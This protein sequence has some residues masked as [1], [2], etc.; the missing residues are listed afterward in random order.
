MVVG[1][2]TNEV[3]TIV[4]GSGPGGYVAA[5]RAAQLGQ[6]VVIVEKETIGG[7]CLN[8]GCIPSKA[9]IQV[10]HDYA[11]SKMVSPYGLSFGETSLDFAKAQ[12]WKNSQVVSK[13]TM[14][15]ETLLK[16]NKVTIVK[17]EAHFVSKDT[18]FVTPEDGLGEGYRFKNVIL[19]LGSRPIELKAFPF[20]GDILDSTGLLNLQ[21]VPKE[22]AI[23]GGGYIGMELAMAYANLG[24]HVTILEGMDRVLGGFEADLVKPVLDQAAQL[25][26]TIITGAKAS[27]YEKTAQGIDLFYQNG[28]KEEKIQADKVAVLVGRRPNTDNV[29][30]EL[31]G[32]D[33]DE[34]GLIPVN[35]QMQTK[36]EHIYAIGDITAGPALA[37][38]ASFEAK[39]AAEAIAQVEGVAA[40]YLVIPTVAYTEPEI[41]TVGLTKA[42][43]KEAGI[44]A[45]VATF[46]FASNGRALSMGN[47]EGFVRLISDKKDNR[48]I[49]AQLVGPGVSELI[50]E[51]TLAIENLLTAEDVTLTIH[52]HPSLAETIMDA[53]EILLGHG[54]HQ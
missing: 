34:K 14:G 51:I 49:G 54:I 31:A 43:A 41:A 19:A 7:A 50:A 13:L 4:I 39:V 16:K 5:I 36:V 1:G 10:G 29:S 21:E 11:H 6:K 22:L 30:I 53:S 35:D 47:S 26:M 15:V 32:L 12:A 9:L 38:K 37:H 18:I 33:L 27:R 3:E 25:G 24:S 45:K 42:A 46:R 52:N 2:Y 8:V 20:G 44:D 17:G 28:E 40:D 23:I 48:M